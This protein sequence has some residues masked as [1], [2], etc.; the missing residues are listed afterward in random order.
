MVERAAVQNKWVL[1]YYTDEFKRD[2]VAINIRRYKNQSAVTHHFQIRSNEFLLFDRTYSSK[3]KRNIKTI[4]QR[5]RIESLIEESSIPHS[6]RNISLVFKLANTMVSYGLT[7]RTAFARAR[8]IVQDPGALPL[9]KD[10]K[11]ILRQYG[12]DPSELKSSPRKV[13]VYKIEQGLKEAVYN[14]NIIKIY[15]KG[16]D[17]NVTGPRFLEPYVFGSLKV[18]GKTKRGQT[19][20]MLRAYQ[21]KGDSSEGWKMFDISKITYLEILPETITKPRAQYN[22]SGDKQLNVKVQVKF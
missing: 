12:V 5:K 22:P 17:E 9:S 7:R 6:N 1:S 16:K 21:V 14:K 13:P 11:T 15:Y 8:S 2:Y 3:N 18:K 10:E 19:K 4:D 20:K